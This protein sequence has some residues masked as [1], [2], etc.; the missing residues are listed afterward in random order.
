MLTRASERDDEWGDD[1]ADP[2]PVS[3]EAAPPR[4]EKLCPECHGELRLNFV[5]SRPSESYYF[6]PDHGKQNVSFA[7]A[8][9]P[10]ATTPEPEVL[11]EKT[12]STLEEMAATVAVKGPMLRELIRGYRLRSPLAGSPP[13]TPEPMMTG[14]I[15][16]DWDGAS[17]LVNV[18]GMVAEIR[19]LAA[20]NAELRAALAEPSP[21]SG[22]LV[23]TLCIAY[24]NHLASDDA[25]VAARAAVDSR[26]AS[27]ER[28]AARMRRMLETATVRLGILR[29]RMEGCR[30]ANAHELSLDEIPAWIEEQ[31]A[32]LAPRQETGT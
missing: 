27:L 6:C 14:L 24:W 29:D 12:L 15:D 16:E 30:E 10:R 23:N 19:R 3:P 25:R 11:T 5:E 20:E 2:R 9:P 31:T 32:A 18:P 13:T 28:D 17:P 21:E 7:E 8:A 4:D 26:L 22:A 1:H